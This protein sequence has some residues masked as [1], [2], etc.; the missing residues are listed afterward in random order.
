MLSK[1]WCPDH[2]RIQVCVDAY[3]NGVPTGRFYH[4]IRE[5][6]KFSSLIQLL[7]QIEAIL[8]EQRLPQSYTAP[9]TFST[10]LEHRD[11][12]LPP[13]ASPKGICATFVLKILFRQHASW[14]GSVIWKEKRQEE[15]FRS[16]LELIRLMDSALRSPEG[17]A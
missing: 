8:D 17:W 14:Q 2:N 7:V 11:T 5:V 10:I 4:S 1:L 3:E 16:V 6:Q 13:P 12:G 9:R 15:S